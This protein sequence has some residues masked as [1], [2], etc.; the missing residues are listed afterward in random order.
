V[1]PDKYARDAQ[2]W[3][4]HGE[5]IYQAA[6]QH[7]KTLLTN[8]GTASLRASTENKRVGASGMNRIRT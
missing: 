1:V 8:M 5:I 6:V 3:I 2:A 7:P 4:A